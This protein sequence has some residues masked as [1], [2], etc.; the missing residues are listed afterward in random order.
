MNNISLT[1][2]ACLALTSSIPLQAGTREVVD[3]LHTRTTVLTGLIDTVIYVCVKIIKD[4]LIDLVI[5]LNNQKKINKGK[6]ECK[7]STLNGYNKKQ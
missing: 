3:A 5:I 4:V 1:P 2:H 7:N 6:A